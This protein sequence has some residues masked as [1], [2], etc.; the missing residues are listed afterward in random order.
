MMIGVLRLATAINLQSLA[1]D[2]TDEISLGIVILSG[3]EAQPTRSRRT[4]TRQ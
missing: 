4:P 2:D 1:Q 3:A